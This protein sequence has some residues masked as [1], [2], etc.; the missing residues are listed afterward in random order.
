M[1]QQ[2]LQD[3][4]RLAAAGIH[5]GFTNYNNNYRRITQR[6]RHRFEQRDWAGARRDLAERIELYDKSVQRTLGALRG[7]LDARIDDLGIWRAIR[8]LYWSRVDDVPDGEFSK[9]FFNSVYRDV[10]RS[11]D[12]DPTQVS[13]TADVVSPEQPQR[14]PARQ[15]NYINWYS[16]QDIVARILGD[17]RFDNRYVDFDGDV[18]F[19]VAGIQRVVADAG[20]LDEAV[21]R[22]EVMQDI[23]YQTSRAFVV[24]QL[25]WAD[26]SC[27]FV[28]AFENRE[29]GVRVEAVLTNPDDVSVLFGFTRS[30]FMCDVEPVEGA[31]DFIKSMLPRKPLDELY[32]ILG[33]ARQGK[34]ERARSFYRH[35]ADCEDHFVHA[36]GDRGLVMLV[37]TLP[38][39]DLVFKVIRDNFGHPKNVSHDEVKKKYKFVFN[40]DRAGRLI[41]TQEFRNIEFPLHKFAPELIEEMLSSTSH[42]VRIDGD[43]L[44]IDHLYSER[45]LTPLNLFLQ[46]YEREQARLAL[47]DYGQAIKDLAMTNI[48]PGDLLLKNFGVSR[49]GR[50]IFYDY[51]ELTLVTDC[52]FRE[53]PEALYP[54]DE[55]RAESWFYVSERDIF[56][57][58]F[59]RF[60]AVEPRL[61]E[62]F[63]DAHGDLLTADYWRSIKR[64]HLENRAP[65]VAPYYRLGAR[66]DAVDPGQGEA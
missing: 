45:R 46:D 2:S 12:I 18:A 26:Q 40:H 47:L 22:I 7:M 56:P 13:D 28:L 32:T 4:I 39:Y 37:F 16:V 15:H 63:L 62:A 55:L 8:V 14:H 36:P 33:R 50:V 34:T 60:I 3:L 49:H 1:A 52:E 30:Y 5:D 20:E 23:F 29:D 58:E 64:L 17:F 66:R 10:L 25:F 42:T 19:V 35:L 41:D 43:Q 59:M 21:R 65:E 53:V 61:R 11:L 57:E 38:S 44:V 54:E 9:T 51:D 48:F 6:A 31:V 24:G 27:P